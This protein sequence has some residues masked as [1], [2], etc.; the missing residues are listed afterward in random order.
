[1]AKSA[2]IGVPAQ[3]GA[4]KLLEYI[5]SS[6]TQY[7]DTGVTLNASTYNRL[8]QVVVTK[9]AFSG[10]CVDGVGKSGTTWYTGVS[11]TT[12]YYGNGSANTA[13]NATA[14]TG[15]KNEFDLDFPNNRYIVKDLDNGVTRLNLTSL[16]KVAP[17]ESYTL[18]LF[19]HNGN[20]GKHS[21]KIYSAKYYLDGVMIRDFVPC[22]NADGEIGMYDKVESKFY[23]NAG[24][25]TFVAG[26]VV[27]EIG[28]ETVEVAREV[29]QMFVGVPRLPA[30]FQEVSYLESTGEQWIDADY[31]PN[32]NS[33]MSLDF[34]PTEVQSTCYAGCRYG[35][36]G[37]GY[38]RAFT[39]NSGSDGTL[40]YA[41][42][43]DSGNVSLGAFTQERQTIT[44][45]KE[46]FIRN[47]V[48]TEVGTDTEL[49]G[50]YT[51]YLFA[52]NT[53]GAKL[54]STC[55][56]Y[57]CM[58]WDGDILVRYFIPCY[59][60]SDKKPGM[61]DLVTG[62]LFTNAGTGEFI[63]GEKVIRGTAQKVKKAWVGVNGVARLFF[64]SGMA[65]SEL[66][67]GALV[68]MN[69]GGVAKNFII[70]HRGKPSSIYDNSC[71]GTWL[72][73]KNIHIKQGWNKSDVSFDGSS[74]YTY[75]ND[76]FLNSLDSGAQA[77]IKQVKIPYEENSSILS[78]ANGLS[79]KVFL[80]GGYET[81]L[82]TNDYKSLPVDGACLSYFNGVGNTTRIAYY[83]STA[84][85][86]WIR[87][88]CEIGSAQAISNN[89]AITGGMYA[90]AYG[91]RPAFILPS[92][93][94]VNPTPNAD[95]SYTLL[96]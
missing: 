29:K 73:M 80:L 55:R 27:E 83:E 34:Q 18:W 3:K 30:E 25:G 2:F 42:Y 96:V 61:Y 57:S 79:T 17:T 4:L 93:V 53:N 68:S 86:W 10:W 66:P 12:I 24:T 8:R 95:G 41:A 44:I 74:H 9:P 88:A 32:E 75:L 36:S 28:G 37:S 92:D 76:T 13:T 62:V 46:A 54:I 14:A 7:I 91:L 26:G 72:L 94:L 69:V 52:C 64:S 51:I 87:S 70:V 82:T 81:G 84:T 5:E 58:I 19:G 78:G 35:T 60:K 90:N 6:G 43:A 56:I 45:S 22:Q 67:V 59:R 16:S 89:G 38:Y 47:G 11:G 65:L 71:D 39:I 40:Q 23:P 48:T 33:K 50:S 85:A 21:A 49:A 63:V 31:N 20:G 15:T 77:I 1:M